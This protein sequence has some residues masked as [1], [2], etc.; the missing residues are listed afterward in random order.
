MVIEP[1]V[2][3]N[4]TFHQFASEWYAK[5][6]REGLRPR[7]LEYL[8]WAL[9]DHLL[10]HFRDHLMP[11]I[12]AQA[13]D[14]YTAAKLG[15]GRLSNGSVNK[16]LEVLATVLELAVEYGHVE[17]NLAKGPRRRLPTTRPQRMHLE[18][19]R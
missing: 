11:E 14:R 16:T 4:P 1:E 3:E 18:Q 19:P 15:E 9:S 2:E 7:T 6:E 13:I 12:T 5:R 8:K 17:L 10:P